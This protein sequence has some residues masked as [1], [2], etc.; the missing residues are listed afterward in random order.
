VATDDGLT[1]LSSDSA[2]ASLAVADG[3]ADFSSE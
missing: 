3:A 2:S 1:D